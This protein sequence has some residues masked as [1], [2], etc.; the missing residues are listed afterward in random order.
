MVLGLS[1]YAQV[2]N[3][4]DILQ[5]AKELYQSIE[6]RLQG[7]SAPTPTR[8]PRDVRHGVAMIMLTTSQELRDAQ[9]ALGM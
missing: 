6:R 9:R 2:T 1:R 7:S 3:S 8:F 4:R 5:F